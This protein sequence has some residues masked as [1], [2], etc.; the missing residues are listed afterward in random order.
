MTPLLALMSAWVTVAPPTVTPLE[1][2]FTSTFAPSTVLKAPDLRL[3]EVI[4]PATTWY[5]RISIRVCRFS[6]LS[7]ALNVS[8]GREAKAVSVGAKTV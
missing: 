6:G 4:S 7:N 8:G 5:F 2:T 1:P 3:L